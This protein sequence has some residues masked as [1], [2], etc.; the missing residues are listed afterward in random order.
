MKLLAPTLLRRQ[1]SLCL[2]VVKQ[3]R[4]TRVALVVKPDGFLVAIDARIE[5][6]VCPAPTQ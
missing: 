2:V 1:P 3:A 6:F 5:V 4:T